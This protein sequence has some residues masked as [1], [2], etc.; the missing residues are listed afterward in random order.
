MKRYE[1]LFILNTAG[2]EDQIQTL[3]DRLSDDIKSAG[4]NIEAVQKMDKRQFVRVANN[5][6][7]DGFYVNVI[8]EA[9]AS[10]NKALETKYELEEWMF[11]MLITHAPNAAAPNTAA[12]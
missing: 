8:F 9:E 3:V 4:G 12:A 10:I 7:A 11:R 6:Y 1:G 2:Q 5:K